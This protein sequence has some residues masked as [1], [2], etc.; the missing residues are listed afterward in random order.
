MIYLVSTDKCTLIKRQYGK[1]DDVLSDF[2]AFLA[3]STMSYNEY[4]SELFASQSLSFGDKSTRENDFYFLLYLKYGGEDLVLLRTGLIISSKDR[5]SQEETNEQL[6]EQ[7]LLR[8]ISHLEEMNK[9]SFS[10]DE[11]MPDT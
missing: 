2:G 6:E 10:E 9:R 4:R 3:F 7:K 1:I 11:V 5:C 8:R